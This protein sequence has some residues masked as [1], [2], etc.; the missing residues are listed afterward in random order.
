MV[1][2][3]AVTKLTTF[4]RGEA[5]GEGSEEQRCRHP[6]GQLGGAAAGAIDSG[7]SFGD[8][9]VHALLRLHLAIFVWAATRRAT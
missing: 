9:V 4:D 6:E 5:G 8:D 2:P 3:S 7:L 1:L